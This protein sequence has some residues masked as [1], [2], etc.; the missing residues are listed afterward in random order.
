MGRKRLLSQRIV[1][2][3]RDPLMEHLG[4]IFHKPVAVRSQGRRVYCKDGQVPSPP[5]ELSVP[6]AELK[7]SLGK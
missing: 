1:G 4:S 3:K 5:Q 2:L 7:L 6:L